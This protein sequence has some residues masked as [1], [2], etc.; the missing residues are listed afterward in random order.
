MVGVGLRQCPE[1]EVGHLHLRSS[2]PPF[3]LR[4]GPATAAPRDLPRG[5]EE[6]R[7]GAVL[8]VKLERVLQPVKAPQPARPL[9]PVVS[10]RWS[11]CHLA[12]RAPMLE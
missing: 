8:Q 3:R 10:V 12:V 6:A 5:G 11:V 9:V 2:R 1:A 7:G 4:A